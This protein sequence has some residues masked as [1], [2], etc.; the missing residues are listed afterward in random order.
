MFDPNAHTSYLGLAI[1]NNNALKGANRNT[2]AARED[3][4]AMRS[5][6]VAL[7][8][9]LQAARAEIARLEDALAVKTASAAGFEAQ[10]RAFAAQHPDSLLMVDSGKR[11]KDGD[12]KRKIRLIYEAAFDACAKT[13]GIMN[14]TSR[15]VD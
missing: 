9:A 15:R 5:G 2:V 7:A 8:V 1:A 12:V 11:Y 4:N 3:A 6:A 13:L 14:P 10:T